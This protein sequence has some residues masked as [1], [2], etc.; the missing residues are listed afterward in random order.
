M[1][2]A[3]IPTVYYGFCENPEL[4]DLYWTVV[5]GIEIR[6][7]ERVQSNHYMSTFQ[8]SG[9]AIAC[10]VA[11]M[12][13]SFRN[14]SFRPYRALMYA[15]LGLS[16]VVFILHGIFLYGWKVQNQRMSLDWMFL[17]ACL[18]L[19]GGWIYA[20]RVGVPTPWMSLV[21]YLIDS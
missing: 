6:V 2:G 4:Q 3:T 16:A 13:P 20:A 10:A 12:H 8:V 17:M 19:A 11:T 5:S 14:P 1:W 7:R 9:L 15:G 21:S 18:N